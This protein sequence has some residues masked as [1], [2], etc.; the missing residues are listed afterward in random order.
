MVYDTSET[1]DLE[2][3]PLGGGILVK[4]LVLSSDPYL[5]EKMREE[6]PGVRNLVVCIQT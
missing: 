2:K 5:R 3:V 1:I 6:V 4:Q